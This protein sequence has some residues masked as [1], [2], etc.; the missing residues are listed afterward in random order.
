M[1]KNVKKVAKIEK[2][3]FVSYIIAFELAAVNSHHYE[4]NTY[5][6]QL[7]CK[8]TVLRFPM[9]LRVKFSNP[10]YL[11]VMKKSDKSVLLMISS[12]SGTL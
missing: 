3:Y 11:R 6:Q 7:I 5:H 1:F 8:Q 2:K 10:I 12:V 9:S 4:E